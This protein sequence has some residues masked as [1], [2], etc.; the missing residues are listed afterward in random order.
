MFDMAREEAKAHQ[1]RLHDANRRAVCKTSLY[2][3]STFYLRAA[4]PINGSKEQEEAGD[5][6]SAPALSKLFPSTL[7]EISGIDF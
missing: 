2:F 1:V 4:P 7:G 6:D 3:F 5:S